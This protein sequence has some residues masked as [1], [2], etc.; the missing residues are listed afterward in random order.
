[1]AT[2]VLLT[3]VDA[4]AASRGVTVV[5]VG[6]VRAKGVWTAV[7]RAATVR[8]AIVRAAARSGRLPVVVTIAEDIPSMMV[9]GFVSV[10]TGTVRHG[11]GDECA[12]L[13][14]G[15]KKPSAL[16]TG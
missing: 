14:S 9:R 13:M 3:A 12:A 10:R 1:M 11:A 16:E 2:I 7:I 6:N 5:L 4:A 15:N 8:A